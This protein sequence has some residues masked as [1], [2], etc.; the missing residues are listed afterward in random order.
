MAFRRIYT[1]LRNREARFS[2]RLAWGGFMRKY[3]G[4]LLGLCLVTAVSCASVGRPQD[5]SRIRT[6]DTQVVLLEY[7]IYLRDGQITDLNGK[8]TAALADLE[9]LRPRTVSPGIV[10]GVVP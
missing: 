1:Y 7:Q 2:G 6:L 8:L 5:V 9:S 3:L 4:A 10:P